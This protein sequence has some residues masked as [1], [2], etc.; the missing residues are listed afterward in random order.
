MKPTTTIKEVKD[1][2]HKLKKA[3]HVHRQSLRLDA[4]GKA[5]A[6]S[7]TLQSLS[8]GDG[9]KLYLRDLGPQISWKS[10]FLVEYAG[11]LVL[12]LWI[13]NCPWI[14]Y[15]DVVASKIDETVK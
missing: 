6:D 10:V 9:G 15:G 2:L 8:I 5:V 7:D 14:F 3:P 12:Y 4:K 1:E 11:P 13:Y